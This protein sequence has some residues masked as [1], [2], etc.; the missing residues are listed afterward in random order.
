MN[1]RPPRIPF[2]QTILFT[3]MAKPKAIRVLAIKG[4]LEKV[5]LH[6]AR[7]EIAIAIRRSMRKD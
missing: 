2:H 6:I 5:I 3:T 4:R 1:H 7:A